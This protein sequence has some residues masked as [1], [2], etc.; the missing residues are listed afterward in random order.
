[1]YIAILPQVDSA[2]GMNGAGETTVTTRFRADHWSEGVEYLNPD[3]IACARLGDWNSP[4]VVRSAADWTARRREELLPGRS[5]I[6]DEESGIVIP[7][8]DSDSTWLFDVSDSTITDGIERPSFLRDDTGHR[9]R[10]RRT[11]GAERSR[12]GALDARA[13][14]ASGSLV[15]DVG[16]RPYAGRDAVAHRAMANGGVG[17]E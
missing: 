14:A 15:S 3:A 5:S 16:V 11:E 12:T 9:W 17:A 7:A 13:F 2:L 10:T 8:P 1:M 4:E 6:A